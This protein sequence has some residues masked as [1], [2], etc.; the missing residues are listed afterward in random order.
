MVSHSRRSSATDM[1]RNS[2]IGMSFVGAGNWITAA[3]G[4]SSVLALP[5]L[6]GA[7]RGELLSVG[8]NDFSQRRYSVRP[9]RVVFHVAPDRLRVLIL[10]RLKV[11]LRCALAGRANRRRL[12]A[13]RAGREFNACRYLPYGLVNGS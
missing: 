10:P 9:R 3:I 1:R 8:R 2:A 5:L 4:A 11:G 12:G 7:G 6:V 13:P